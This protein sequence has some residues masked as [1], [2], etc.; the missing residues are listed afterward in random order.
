MYKNN[1]FDKNDPMLDDISNIINQREPLQK[2]YADAAVNAGKE[3]K[4][5]NLEDR[6][7]VYQKHMRIA[8]SESGSMLAADRYV[9]F[10]QIANDQL[11]S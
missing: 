2:E 1:R 3:A 10:E 8:Q 11:G 9:E 4:G 5:L 7:T 6:K